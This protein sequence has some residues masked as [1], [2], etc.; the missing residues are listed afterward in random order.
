[1]KSFFKSIGEIN[2]IVILVLIN[3]LLML[4]PSLKV[5]LTENKI[6][7]L[8][9]ISKKIA[10]DVDNIL[11]IKVFVSKDLPSDIKPIRDELKSLL[12]EYEKANK[13][14]IKVSFVDPVANES[15]GAEAEKL[16]IQK[17]Q[18]STLKSN[19]LEVSNGYFG[20]A[21]SYGGKNDV[22]PVIKDVQNLEYYV[23]SAIKRLTVKK[24]AMVALFENSQTDTAYKYFEQ[25]LGNSYNTKRININIDDITD[26]V[27]TLIILDN[28]DKLNDKAVAS[29]K[30]ML[31]KGKSVLI[32]MNKIETNA[33]MSGKV[34]PDTGIE[35]ILRENGMEIENKLILDKSAAV[36][37][38]QTNSGTFAL[39]Y[40]YWIK[41]L[42]ENFNKDVP[43]IAGLSSVTFP[44]VSN[45]KLSDGAVAL[46]K[47][48]NESFAN[49][50][51]SNLLPM[52]QKLPTG[53]KA[54]SLPVAAVNNS[55]SG[56]IGVV[57]DSDF[58]KDQFFVQNQ[59]NMILAL[60][61]TDY[62][63]QDSSMASI[64]S[65]IIS[66]NPIKIISNK[67]QLIIE[68]GNVLLPAILL[69]IIGMIFNL[70]RKIKN[71]RFNE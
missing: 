37:N 12:S 31:G 38:F 1:M 2:F 58:F 29:I 39:E 36:A 55:K 43:A 56:R 17:L 13:K 26:D 23:D 62:F 45:I 14:N 5:D 25:F 3:V 68:W 60:N 49:S 21:I 57:A 46:V 8:S 42:P 27:E 44:W 67:L 9:P 52:D 51:L 61:L 32:F 10:K 19:K 47:S 35:K 71:N 69:T 28:Q 24:A 59:Q 33:N 48:S 30:N 11:N 20:L 22:L 66:S 64:R 40:P 65:K 63:S 54:E 53:I 50:D 34:I 16:G 41:I 18:F 6:H 4:S 7:S 70:I 15:I